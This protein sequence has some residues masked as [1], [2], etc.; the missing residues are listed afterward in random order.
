MIKQLSFWDQ[1]PKDFTALGCTDGADISWVCDTTF[2]TKFSALGVSMIPSY[3]FNS[4]YLGCV[5]QECFYKLK[6]LLTIGSKQI[7]ISFPHLQETEPGYEWIDSEADGET[8]HSCRAVGFL[9]NLSCGGRVLVGV[10]SLYT[11]TGAPGL[12]QQWNARKK[13]G[14]Q[15]Q[16][17]SNR[18]EKRQNRGWCKSH[19]LW[20]YI[21]KSL[22]LMGMDNWLTRAECTRI[23]ATLKLMHLIN[24]N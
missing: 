6:Y 9:G 22:F 2:S 14:P 18:K 4:T 7:L 12:N 15:V 23:T 11:E 1:K 5:C 19:F 16:H 3:Q 20:L 10:L 13:M 21:P 24:L 17:S 8:L